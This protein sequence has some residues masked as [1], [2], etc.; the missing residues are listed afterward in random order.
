[1]PHY[2]FTG[3]LIRTESQNS[4]R[5]TFPFP[6]F[7]FANISNFDWEYSGV[8]EEEGESDS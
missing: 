8:A 1:M 7:L 4:P 6:S 2:L 3:S 5:W